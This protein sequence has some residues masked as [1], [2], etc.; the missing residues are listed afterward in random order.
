[1]PELGGLRARFTNRVVQKAIAYSQ[2]GVP[3]EEIAA[4]LWYHHAVEVN[5]S[6]IKRWLDAA[7]LG[8]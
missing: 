5:P 1:M 7:K 2:G 3:L 8:S 4:R 6:T